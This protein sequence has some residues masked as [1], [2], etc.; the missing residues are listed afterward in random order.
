[1]PHALHSLRALPQALHGA[2]ADVA[3]TA[4]ASSDA[5]RWASVELLTVSRLSLL[6][7]VEGSVR[8][9]TAIEHGSRLRFLLKLLFLRLIPRVLWLLT[10]FR[11]RLFDWE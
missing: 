2:S 9:R 7:S 11:L 5:D 1:M 6:L 8:L 10:C 3:G 4:C